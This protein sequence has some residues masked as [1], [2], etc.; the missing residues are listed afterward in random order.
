M[1]EISQSSRKSQTEPSSSHKLSPHLR[2]NRPVQSPDGKGQSIRK[3]G[4]AGIIKIDHRMRAQTVQSHESRPRRVC[5]EPF[6]G[7]DR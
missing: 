1:I 5:C 7:Y 6:A 4:G 2:R 3:A